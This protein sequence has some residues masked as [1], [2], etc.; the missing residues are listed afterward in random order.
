MKDVRKAGRSLFLWTV[1]DDNTMR[2]SISKHVD[3]VITDDPKRYLELCKSFE[4]KKVKIALKGWASF[5]FIK[6]LIP[7]Y[8]TLIQKRYGTKWGA[9]QVKQ[10][11]L[12]AG[13]DYIGT[14]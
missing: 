11:I 9:G 7:F 2:W 12:I 5:T 10:D 13:R 3:G 1:N 4:G 8:R 14:Q 6:I